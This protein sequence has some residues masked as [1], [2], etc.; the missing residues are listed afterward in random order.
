MNIFG[1]NKILNHPKKIDAWISNSPNSLITVEIDLTNVCNHRCPGCIGWMDGNLWENAHELNIKEVINYIDQLKNLDAK[2]IIFTGGG[3][4]TCHKNWREAVSY[5][6]KFFDVGF[7]TNG[8]LLNESDCRVLLEKC[9]WVRISLDAGSEEIFQKTHGVN[10]FWKV[11]DNIKLLCKLKTKCTVGAGYLT[12]SDTVAADMESFA[13]ICSLAGIDYYQFRPFHYE[14]DNDLT[15]TIKEIC[16]KYPNGT[17]SWQ[18]YLSTDDKRIYDSCQGAHFCTTICADAKVYI[19]CHMRGIEKYC[20]GNLREQKM[21]EIWSNRHEIIER[22]G[23]FQDCPPLCRCDSF[24][25]ILYDIKGQKDHV[26]FL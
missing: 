24:N 21:S 3:D 19:C 16:K 18:K 11:V 12:G 7:I 22:V 4:P 5:A 17:A 23:N 26:N 25:K 14:C 1:K 20:L 10:T 2:A 9:S 6:S 13:K 15:N 8:L